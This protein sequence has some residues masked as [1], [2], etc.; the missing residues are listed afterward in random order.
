M[1]DASLD[2]RNRILS[3]IDSIVDVQQLVTCSGAP[4]P[5]PV[6]VINSLISTTDGHGI[7]R[8]G[9]DIAHR[10]QNSN[11]CN[12]IQRSTGYVESRQPLQSGTNI[13]YIQPRRR[14]S[15]FF[16]VS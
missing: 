6:G 15:N 16:G 10:D 7:L 14:P 11:H 5:I 9:K 8:L 2:L 4:V 12:R 1:R 3:L 13:I